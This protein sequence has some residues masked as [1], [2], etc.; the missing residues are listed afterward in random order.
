MTKI[1]LE[2]SPEK[3]LGCSKKGSMP[4]KAEGIVSPRAVFR[5]I[6]ESILAVPSRQF[7]LRRLHHE[8]ILAFRERPELDLL[9]TP[10][11]VDQGSPEGGLAGDIAGQANGRGI[12]A[13]GDLDGSAFVLGEH[14]FQDEM[15]LQGFLAL[16]M[17]FAD[18]GPQVHV[19]RGSHVLEEEV[20]Q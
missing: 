9:D 14:R 15:F 1:K 12:E 7:H 5:I 6:P 20:E 17:D 18:A 2:W 11:A 8:M 13:G 10:A 3:Y 19:G 16:A 4:G